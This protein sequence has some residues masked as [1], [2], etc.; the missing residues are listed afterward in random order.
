MYKSIEHPTRQLQDLSASP[1]SGLRVGAGMVACVREGPGVRFTKAGVTVDSGAVSWAGCL[2]PYDCQG[3]N[4]ERPSGGRPMK[5]NKE[6]SLF[7]NL[8]VPGKISCNHM[9]KYGQNHSYHSLCM[10]IL[11]SADYLLG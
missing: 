4:Q 9:Q 7:S 5:F 10:P 11:L 3:R 2:L 6:G 1:Q 8:F